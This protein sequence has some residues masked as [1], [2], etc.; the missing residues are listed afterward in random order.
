MAPGSAWPATSTATWKT[1]ANGSNW[2]TARTHFRYNDAGRWPGR[3]DGKGA[4]LLID[5]PADVPGDQLART[6]YLEDADH[7][8][9]S[10]KL[11][12]TPGADPQAPLGVVI[13]EVLS[14][15]DWPL[16]D[17][18]ELHN[19][20]GAPIDVGGWYLSDSWGWASQPANGNYKKF[21]IP[22]NT[23]DILPGGYLVFN[24]LN[25]NPTPGAPGP[26]DFALDGAHGDDVWLMKADAQ[27]NLTHFGDHVDFGAQFNGES[28][29]RWPN[30]SGGLY[31]MTVPPTLPGANRGPRLG[32]V[33]ISEV[34]YRPVDANPAD[35]FD[36]DDLEFVEIFNTT[37]A[38]VTLTDWRLRKGVD[39]DF[40]E[41]DS[42]PAQTA[43]VIV[44]FDPAVDA[45]AL[46]VFRAAYGVQGAI[47]IRGPYRQQLADNGE[48]VQLQYPDEEPGGEPNFTPHLLEDEVVYDNEDYQAPWPAAADG[49]GK[50]LSRVGTAVWGNA[51][52]SWSAETPNPGQGPS[53]STHARVI[54]RH[55]FYN[56][57][58]F[59]ATSDDDAI[60]T[61]K[62]PLLPGGTAAFANYTSYSRGING[63]MVDLAGLPD[64][65]VPAAGDFEF[66]VGNDTTPGGWAAAAGPSSITFHGGAGDGGSDRVTITWPDGAIRNAWLQVTVLAGNLQL[67][68]NDVFY[69]GNAVA[70]GGNAPDGAQVTT[71]DLLLARNNPRDFLDS[72][73]IEFPYD[74]DR[75]G[76]VNAT[77]VLLARNNQTNFLNAL[78][79]ID[80]SAEEETPAAESLAELAWLHEAEQ[81][82]G[83]EATSKAG[84]LAA[85]DVDLLLA[86]Q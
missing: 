26:N 73:A 31:P 40:V 27:G 11:G 1:P 65:V 24:E 77:D 70:E 34:H 85:E 86:T 79:L 68:G 16:W 50:S 2:H 81:D 39:F 35:A 8:H 10:V 23:P 21:K 74:Y 36:A 43:M 51:A 13:N 19:P 83:Q 54:G 38:A 56:G 42:I 80:L 72:A 84:S 28:W 78:R 4:T 47:E 52:A 7:W 61:D 66:H 12:G 64:G 69:F 41:G 55:V 33:I 49:G 63:V 44:S 62:T 48:R 76:H 17:T 67:S 5:D 3:A 60:A 82:A 15:T 53:G 37:F 57:S 9:S 29:G 46:A 25:F 59:D 30:G 45:D 75:D 32:S 71:T 6:D 18:I 20:T 22:D 14:H 58:A